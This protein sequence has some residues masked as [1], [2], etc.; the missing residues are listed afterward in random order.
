[1]AQVSCP[2]CKTVLEV[3]AE[4]AGQ[5]VACPTCQATFTVPAAAPAPAVAAAP[6]A[7]PMQQAG[8][9]FNNGM[10]AAGNYAN[11]ALNKFK[12]ISAGQSVLTIVAL[13]VA[14]VALAYSIFFVD[15]APKV[16]FSKDAKTACKNYLKYTWQANALDNYDYDKNMSIV[17]DV[18]IG[19]VY[20]N[21]NFAV[22]CY[23]LKKGSTESKNYMMLK[24]NKDG[25]Y[26]K[27]AVNTFL[28][29]KKMDEEWY[30]KTAEKL[31]NFRG[32]KPISVD[33][34]FD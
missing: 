28:P 31:D 5:N 21:G 1:M 14:I 29:D 34:L 15:S 6:A 30:S 8:A 2:Q 23:T 20:E 7:A 3:P 9:M 25:Y 22:V 13:V 4:L 32:S 19:D 17:N 26:T 33:T 12:A 24:K 10:A 11:A 27:V 16:K 18:V